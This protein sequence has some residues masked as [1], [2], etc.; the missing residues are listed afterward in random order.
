M[1]AKPKKRKVEVVVISDVHLGTSGCK[2]EQL[3]RYLKTVQPKKLILNGDI[4]DGWQFKKSYFPKYHTLVLKQILSIMAKG[5]KVYY[6]T[7]NHDELMRKFAGFKLGNFS[8]VNKVILRLNGKKAWVFHGDVFDV[9]M[10]H[11]KWLARLGSIGYDLLLWLNRTVNWFLGLVGREPYSFSKRIK[12]SV[13]G[14]V[15]FINHFEET[16]A[17]IAAENS[18]DYVVCGHIHAP[19]IRDFEFEE[20]RVTYLNSGDWVESL[21]GLEYDHGEWRIYR[22]DQDE[23]AKN[24]SLAFEEKQDLTSKK[25]FNDLAEDVIPREVIDSV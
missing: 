15:T 8:V 20:G 24:A 4:I 10:K 6:V 16:A 12:A 5:A 11:S 22:F 18:Y 25:L 2:A 19:E 3:F 13:K 9:V 21:T 17:R 23:M 14:A 1:G 7:G